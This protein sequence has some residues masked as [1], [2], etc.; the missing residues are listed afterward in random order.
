[1][2][3]LPATA[4]QRR[5]VFIVASLLLVAFAFAAPFGSAKLPQYVSFNPVV[6][7]IVFVTDFITAV[8]LSCNIR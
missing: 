5:G 8:F 4:Q 3:R 1:M 7:A 6:Q 2:T